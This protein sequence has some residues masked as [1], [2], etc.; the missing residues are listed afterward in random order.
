LMQ[1]GLSTLTIAI[2]FEGK[3]EKTQ[4]LQKKKLPL[5]LTSQ[6]QKERR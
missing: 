1:S 3:R 5:L 6:N 4:S 2:P